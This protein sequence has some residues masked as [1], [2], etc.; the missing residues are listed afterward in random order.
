M[1]F[2]VLL[3]CGVLHTVFG[4]ET[5][6]DVLPLRLVDGDSVCSGRVEVLYN[7]TW[8][9]ICDDYWDMADA[10][11]VCRQ[12]NCGF[13]D[14][15]RGA[16]QFGE[17]TEEIWLD[18]VECI[19]TETHLQQCKFR[20]IGEH[21]CNHVEDAGVICNA[22]LAPRP[23]IYQGR[24]SNIFVNGENLQIKCS[25]QGYYSA[26]VFHLYK[27]SA[28]TPVMSKAP[29]SKDFTVTFEI[30]NITIR[31]TG[32]Y[33]CSYNSQIAGKTFSSERSDEV[34]IVMKDFLHPPIITFNQM[35]NV[36]VKG[37]NLAIRCEAPERFENCRFYLYKESE[38]NVISSLMAT[39]SSSNV[40]FNIT[41]LQKSDEGSYFCRYQ[42]LLAKRLL[43]NSSLSDSAN[44]T[45]HDDVQLRLVSKES[46]CA[47]MVEVYYNGTWGKVCGGSWNLAAG[48]VACRHLG[49]GF[50][51]STPRGE[52]FQIGRDPV[53]LNHVHCLGTETLLWK[54]SP[55]S[56]TDVTCFSNFRAEVACS[57]RPL[58]PAIS[59]FRTPSVFMQGENVTVHCEF[60][61]FYTG[62]RMFLYKVGEKAPVLTMPVPERENTVNFTLTSIQSRQ[63]GNYTCNFDMDLSELVFSS[64]Q[65]EQQMITVKDEPPEPV[66]F[67]VKIPPH[68]LPGQLIR[69]QCRAPQYFSVI[70]Y[71]LFKDNGK[72]CI[73]SKPA[74][75]QD[76]PAIFEVMTEGKKDEGDYTCRYEMKTSGQLYNSSHSE[77]LKI[78]VI[79]DIKL[80]LADGPVPC[81]GRVEGYAN[82]TWGTI[83]DSNWGLPDAEVVCRQLRCGFVRSATRS[84]R[85]GEGTGPVW[86]DNV[87]CNGTEPYLWVCPFDIAGP[88]SC[89]MTTD[90]GVICSD[91]PLKPQILMWR[92]LGKFSQGEN[93][94]IQCSSPKFYT[95]ATFYLYKV[96]ES[97]HIKTVKAS[98]TSN[99]VT[100][101]RAKINTGHEGYYICTYQLE[102]DGRNYTSEKSDQV[103]VIVIDKP[104]KPTIEILR[105]TGA[106]SIGETANIKCSTH[107]AYSGVIFILSKVES[108]TYITS[109]VVKAAGFSTILTV[110]DIS[111][112]DQGD[113]VCLYQIKRS[114]KLFNSTQ[115]DRKQLTVTDELQ[116]P[117]VSQLR[118]SGQYLEG[119]SA[120][121]Q[122][123][124]PK[125]YTGITFTLH[126]VGSTAVVA[127]FGPTSNTT[128]ILKIRNMRSREEGSYT[129]MYQASVWG[130]SYTSARSELLNVTLA[131]QPEGP[132]LTVT[133]LFGLFVQGKSVR[134]TCLAPEYYTTNR[135]HLIK[136]GK[137]TNLPWIPTQWAHHGAEFRIANTTVS[138]SGNYTC[139]YETEINGNMFNS[140]YS[141]FV[142]I[143]VSE[144]VEIRLMNGSSICS[145]RVEILN[146]KTWGT[147]CDDQ[148]QLA[149]AQIVCRELRCGTAVSALTHA[150]FGKGTGPIVLDDLDCRGTELFLWQCPS[151][152]WGQHNCHHEEDA[153]VICSGPKPRLSVL[154]DYDVFVKGE[155]LTLKCTLKSHNASKRLEFLR[156]SVYLSHQEL[157]PEDI[158]ATLNL[159]NIGEGDQGDYTCHYVYLEG[160]QWIHSTPSDPV[161]VTITDTL[162]KPRGNSAGSLKRKGIIGLCVGTLIFLVIAFFVGNHYRK[163]G[164]IWARKESRTHHLQPL[165]VNQEELDRT[166]YIDDDTSI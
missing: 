60:S 66:I 100:F 135:F 114:G 39:D 111:S 90:A 158:S 162:T 19:G 101:T 38:E 106:F 80:R 57:E 121:I 141:N 142:V 134:I 122:C 31:N 93:I 86:G 21:N 120:D 133:T 98:A 164:F 131:R 129:C 40:V 82:G 2:S 25:T 70:T 53:Q 49:C 50:V 109:A 128:V 72:N 139:I 163:S 104:P 126:K 87:N 146:N 81:S 97:A 20:T 132:K 5:P 34:D 59:V 67:S 99:S 36:F 6:Q 46:D 52:R 7:E 61:S 102:R 45:V 51:K 85:F 14:S 63:T 18:D 16:A 116:R 136:N 145:G 95:G 127:S 24:K 33:S 27:D 155:S 47:G 103:K 125:V 44:V 165:I 157:N 26:N 79:A 35:P 143:A 64:E 54:C 42:A 88:R 77:P 161:Q 147:V 148:W 76:S 149:D 12:L 160:D 11:V 48:Q 3:F 62:S 166:E 151:R 91:T 138:D 124:A 37:Q 105:P 29:S 108:N 130:R 107:D 22:D 74:V 15:A 137:A 159:K 17:G 144:R 13:V 58:K 115:S 30:L 28:N 78:T 96:G 123:S 92:T 8:G 153:G 150:Y 32:N 68:F 89:P 94:S 140:T 84:G 152:H 9:T 1:R 119:Q 112:K 117:A 83:C 118:P 41:D 23:A 110:K 75:V 69:L 113:Y 43:V 56:W 65:S 55:L 154:P 71:Y 4:T 10:V 156:N 73:S